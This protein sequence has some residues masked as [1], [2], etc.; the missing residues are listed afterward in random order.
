RRIKVDNVFH[1]WIKGEGVLMS[2]DLNL[3]EHVWKQLKQSLDD[4]AP[5]PIDLTELHVALVEDSIRKIHPCM[6]F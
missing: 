6:S 5:P 1:L 3:E 4:C 2:P